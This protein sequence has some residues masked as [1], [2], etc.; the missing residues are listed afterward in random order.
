MFNGWL[1]LLTRGRVFFVTFVAPSVEWSGDFG[2]RISD[3]GFWN[4]DFGMEGGF[5]NGGFG[6]WNVE[7][8]VRNV[9]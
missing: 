8:G 6:I 2:F 3:F 7:C 4:V 1:R 5:R 9:E